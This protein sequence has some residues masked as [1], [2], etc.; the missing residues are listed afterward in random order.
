MS[1]ESI[2]YWCQNI[3]AQAKVRVKCRRISESFGPM[4][5][6]CLTSCNSLAWKVYKC[7]QFK[8]IY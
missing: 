3:N 8:F 4:H 1:D 2:S 7:L 6:F 5:A